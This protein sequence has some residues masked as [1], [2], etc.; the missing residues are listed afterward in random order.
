MSRRLSLLPFFSPQL[1]ALLGALSVALLGA[2]GA[3]A[4]RAGTMA[5]PDTTEI[6]FDE[7][8][9]TA[10]DQNTDIKRAQAQARQSNVQVRAEW[11]DF[12][13]DLSLGV[14]AGRNFGRNFSPL[15][16]EVITRTSDQ[17][18]GSLS[19]GI[20]LFNGFENTASLNQAQNLRRADET[21]L[22]R[23][24]R[25]VVFTVMDQYIAFIESR[26]IVRV[27]REE[28]EARR[29][30]LRQIEEFVDAGSRP[31]SDLYQEQA[32]VAEAEQNL[33]QAQREREVN[34]TRLIQTLQ[35]N[36]RRPYRF[37]VPDLAADTLT[38]ERYDL[39]A[40]MDE[41]FENRLD[42]QVAQAERRAAEKGVR[43]ARSSYYPSLSLSV[44]YGTDWSDQRTREITGT[45]QPPETVLVEPATGG[46]PVSIPI[47][48]TGSAPVRQTPGFSDQLQDN[49]SGS[50]ELSLN[51]PIFDRF[52]R[53]TQ[54]ERAQVQAQN[55]Q[56]Q[57]EDQRQQ[58]ALQVRQAYLDYRNAVQQLEAANKRLR[59]ARQA[60]AAAQERYNLGSASIVELQNA[61]RD[62][63]DAAS[64]Q[65]RARYNLIF[66]KKQID[67]HVGR[68]RPDEP[69][70]QRQDAQ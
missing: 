6:G 57:L 64:R 1:V 12:A 68:L 48:G 39:S 11:M 17:F 36:P 55:A 23:T 58:V 16:G 4:Q 62:F 27:R 29:Q 49:R 46:D 34:K 28:L 42:L 35:L 7:A 26:E 30:Q 8:V 3:H 40:L 61:T 31:I 44:G 67:Y 5:A 60:R 65:V 2:P 9:R 43:A 70:I 69:L 50:V 32:N 63:V 53:S 21:S 14:G 38:T 47:L 20:T 18:G 24:R 22:Q 13:P 52:Q 54:V 33:L 45:A 15:E 19:S 66:Q 51:I 25:E 41:A 59:A 56:Y 10:L 37:T